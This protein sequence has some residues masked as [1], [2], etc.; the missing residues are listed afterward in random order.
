MKKPKTLA[1]QG[2]HAPEFKHGDP[3]YKVLEDG[4]S[5][6]GGSLSWSLPDGG[7]PGEWHTVEGDVELCRNGLHLTFDP[8]QHWRH[9]RDVYLAE[10]KGMTREAHGLKVACK[11]ARLLRRLTPAE[12]VELGLIKPWRDKRPLPKLTAAPKVP[13]VV[14]EA[15]PSAAYCFVRYVW[16]NNCK[17]VEFSWRTLNESLRRA[18]TLAIEAGLLFSPR[19]FEAIYGTMRGSYWFGEGGEYL[20]KAAV[21]AGNIAACRSFEAWRCRPALTIDGKRIAIGSSFLWEG[22]SVHVTS[23]T[24]T[25]VI[26]CSYKRAEEERYAP[27]KVDRRHAIPFADFI[28]AE[29]ARL[30]SLEILKT[31]ETVAEMLKDARRPVDVAVVAMWTDEERDEAG[32]WAALA[33]HD[34]DKTRVYSAP[35]P[36]HVTVGYQLPVPDRDLAMRCVV[37]WQSANYAGVPSDFMEQAKEAGK[38]PAKK[39]KVAK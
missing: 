30:A 11:S 24:P 39:G 37:L 18:L 13:K 27:A 26:A 5:C 1:A 12:M 7:K 35:A 32:G 38:K 17:A 28:T 21:E 29:R 33:V 23:F 20:Y 36:A 8:L 14:E 19:D 31:A 22:Q 10:G 2:R 15:K 34:I 6:D 9:G 25:A 16:D 3:L 4:E